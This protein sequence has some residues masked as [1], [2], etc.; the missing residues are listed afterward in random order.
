MA[1]I[2]S[3]NHVLARALVRHAAVVARA[4]DAPPAGPSLAQD[5]GHLGRVLLGGLLL[6]LGGALVLTLWLLA[7]GL[8]LALLGVALIA[9]P[10]NPP[11]R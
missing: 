11:P 9:A 8:P 6:L 10:G 1:T 5:L 2:Q 3:S 7:V 4:P